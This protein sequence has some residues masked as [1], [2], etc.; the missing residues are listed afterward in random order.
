MSNSKQEYNLIPELRELN[1][2]PLQ[3]KIM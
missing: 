2:C 3:Q 1:I